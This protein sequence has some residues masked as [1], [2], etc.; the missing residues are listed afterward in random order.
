MPRGLPGPVPCCD[1]ELEQSV[2]V[3][4]ELLGQ[5]QPCALP[6]AVEQPDAYLCFQGLD[7]P[8]ERGLGDVQPRGG[9]AE[10]RL[11]GDRHEIAQLP[12]INT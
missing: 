7:L 10:V 11:G 3:V 9:P 12:Q 8:A 5:A 2:R 6:A 1:E 4:A